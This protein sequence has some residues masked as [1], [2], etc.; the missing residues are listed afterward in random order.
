MNIGPQLLFFISALGV[1]NGVLMSLYFWAFFKSQRIQNRF[2]GLLLLMLSIRIGKSVF[3]FFTEGLSPIILQLGLS[4][5][6]F[7]GPL[8]FLYIR[9][10]L[11]KQQRLLQQDKWHLL[12]LLGVMVTIGVVFPYPLRPDLWNPEIVQGIYA[13]WVI[14]LIAGGYLLRRHIALVFTKPSQL[15][16]IE[17]WLLVVWGTNAL[18]CG[19]FNSVLYLGFPSYILGPITFSFVFYALAAFLIIHPHSKSI[20][21][22]EKQRYVNKQLQGKQATQI[23]RQLHAL[24][25]EKQCFANPSLKLQEV[26]QEINTTPHLL[27][28]VLNDHL[29]K[30]FPE[31][32]NEYRVKAACDLLHQPHNLTM[33]GVGKEVGFRSKSAFY[34]A[35]KKYKHLTPSQFAKQALAL[36]NGS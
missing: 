17:K 36:S 35:F 18:I 16:V 3:H 2:F 28:Q 19:V 25:I 26:A 29:G 31:F 15:T 5:C 24:M 23:Q 14:Y 4:A 32:I 20:I 8:V 7:I 9:S 6:F 1:F 30:S 13:V 11:N 22:G 34:A 21:E 27:S 33:E 12:G 10:V